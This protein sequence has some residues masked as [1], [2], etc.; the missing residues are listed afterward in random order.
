MECL[1]RYQTTVSGGIMGKCF[2]WLVILA[3]IHCMPNF[4]CAG[5]LSIVPAADAPKA[6]VGQPLDPGGVGTETL[7]GV[8]SDHDGVRDDVQRWI[9]VTYPESEATRKALR[10]V[11]VTM[12]RFLLDVGYP[13]KAFADAYQMGMDT[14]CVAYI[15]DDFYRILIEH[16]AVFLN[17]RLRTRAWLQVDHQLSGR[18]FKSLNYEDWKK[19]C[20]FDVD[21]M[22]NEGRSPDVKKPATD[23]SEA[24]NDEGIDFFLPADPGEAGKATL[25]GIDFDNDGVR[26]DVQ[27]W[28]AMTYPNSEKT[29]A[30]LRQRAKTMQRFLLRAEMPEQAYEIF[31]QMGE[32]QACLSYVQPQAYKVEAEFRAVILNSTMRSSVWFQGIQ[33]LGRRTQVALDY[34]KRKQWCTFNPD[35][36]PN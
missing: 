4:S 27:R 32:A 6:L 30:A 2:V 26:D 33:K 25:E 34:R 16:K 35:E 13:D 23:A 18:M 19:A 7:E 20:Q 1:N 9:A 12:Q 36:M 14:D 5:T 8:D 15:R 17:T 11:T 21:A 22:L 3:G 29:R 31:I 28:I 24:V 10:Q